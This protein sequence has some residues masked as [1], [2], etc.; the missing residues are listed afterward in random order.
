MHYRDKVRQ[1][2]QRR[3]VRM[4]SVFG[5]SLDVP[6]PPCDHPDAK[7]IRLVGSRLKTATASGR[8]KFT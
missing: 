5:T 7:P 4:A 6:R 1:D 3:L 8:L 2:V